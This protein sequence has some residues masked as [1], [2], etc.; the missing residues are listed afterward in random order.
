MQG[1]ETWEDLVDA[2]A[3]SPMENPRRKDFGCDRSW[4]DA[5]RTFATASIIYDV[6][7][8]GEVVD[9]IVRFVLLYRQKRFEASRIL[10]LES[11]PA[12]GKTASIVKA[13]LAVYGMTV[14]T[15]ID[16]V[17]FR[18]EA[19]GSPRTTAAHIPVV[20]ASAAGNTPKA[21]LARPVLSFLD[22]ILAADKSTDLL[23]RKFAKYCR[24]FE[25]E[26]VILDDICHLTKDGAGK[27]ID[28][29]KEFIELVPANVVFVGHDLTRS[30]VA[31]AF[32]RAAAG[33]QISERV[34]RQLRFDMPTIFDTAELVR[35][36][37]ERCPLLEHHAGCLDDD[38]IFYIHDVSG[39][40]PRR[41]RDW[42][43]HAIFDL[44]GKEERL[45]QRH[46]EE[47]ASLVPLIPVNTTVS[48]G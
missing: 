7:R 45:E 10:T 16:P 23:I 38:A 9:E 47:C 14:D 26:L 20:L 39:G 28:A 36:I 25:V 21:A 5:R 42:L 4:N 33:A 29:L 12:T 43:D 18:A 41:V 35:S 40:Y 30:A 6:E 44:I 2:A 24:Q 11:L 32:D 13:A 3:C 22:E 17:T 8:V 15:C 19:S 37:E 46:L 27:A 34:V 1:I 48:T 31:P